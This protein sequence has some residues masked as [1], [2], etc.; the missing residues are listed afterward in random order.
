MN[1]WQELIGKITCADCLDILKQ[2]PDKCVDL[3]LT[4]PPYGIDY[5]GQLAKNFT[6]QQKGEV[7]PK[8]GYKNYG[9]NEWDKERPSQEIFNELLR[10]SK[11]QIIWGGELFC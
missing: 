1:D 3:V 8:N 10:V 2:L 9:V 6:T 7:N 5:G 4:D 11:N